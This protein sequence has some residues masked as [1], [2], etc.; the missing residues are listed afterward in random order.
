MSTKTILEA[1]NWASLF[2]EEHGR[3]KNVGELLLLHHLGFTR[4]QLLAYLPDPIGDEA[5]TAF[6]RD[7]R[8]HA[9]HG[10][11]YQHLVGTASF[12]GR[13]FN[14]NKH[15][16][17]PR[18]ETEELVDGILRRL[19]ERGWDKKQI[20]AVDIGTGSGIIP[21]TLK[22]EWPSMSVSAVDLS[23][24]ALCV[25]KRNREEHGTDI[26]FYEGSFLE[27]V[28]DQTFDLIVSNPPYIPEGDLDSLSDVVKNYDPHLALFAGKDG[29]DA[30]R[31]I[32]AQLPYVS[33][34]ETLLAFEIGYNQ[35]SDVRNLIQS[36]FPAST[37]E[38]V[39]DLN[40]NE[41][42]VFAWLSV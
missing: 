28:L 35:G 3:E 36:K 8:E 33:K 6:E 29:L 25:A 2:L 38:V 21:I 26:T 42:M 19:N 13:E 32:V 27:P 41:R 9:L 20:H 4:A 34:S 22:Q 37:P 15:V 1:R 7:V 18:Q 16:L 31:A 17:V 10:V 39:N 24:D 14:V 5:Y 30:Y 23:A 11:P 40:G 12:F